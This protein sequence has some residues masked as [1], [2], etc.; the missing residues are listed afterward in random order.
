MTIM[1][2]G[3]SSGQTRRCD[4][5]CHYASG[6]KCTCICGGRYHG[7]KHLAQNWLTEDV[8]GKDWREQKAKIEAAG[9]N[10]ELVVSAAIRGALAPAGSPGEA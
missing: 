4:A 2:Q 8:L 10:Y 7:A 6:P 5:S 3:S 1:T 9:G